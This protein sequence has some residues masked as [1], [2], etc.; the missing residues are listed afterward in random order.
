MVTI[1]ARP[2]DDSHPYG[3]HKAE[4]FSAGL[5]GI[6]IMIAA[7][8][9]F[10]E[11]G[12]RLLA[13][14]AITQ[15][16]VG[17]ILSVISSVLNGLLALAMFNASKNHHSVVLEADARHLMTDVWTS[18]G[19]VVGILLATLTG[20]LWLDAAIAII[21]AINILREGF[22]L[23]WQASQGLMD[24]ALD[25][26]DI[27]QIE[28]ILNDFAYTRQG[29]VVIRFD[30]LSTRK[31]GQRKF[32][33]LHMHVP[34]NWSLGRA[35]ALRMNVEQALMQTIPGLRVSIQLLPSHTEAHVDKKE[36]ARKK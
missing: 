34:E 9:I 19:V 14:Q 5:E 18:V 7:V 3:H 10:V 25:A 15:V 27:T 20:W 22:K 24:A 35:A 26:K 11:A 23:V 32:A 36:E 17:M 4:Y 6:L 1:A 29:G 13:P 12:Q 21:V 30:H 2:P 16:G 8:F 31:A 28:E 33:D